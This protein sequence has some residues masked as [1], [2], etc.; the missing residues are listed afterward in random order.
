[1]ETSNAPQVPASVP[2]MTVERFS[3]L[4]GLTADTIRGQI[5]QGNLPFIKVGRRRL[6]NVALLTAEC[7]NAEDWS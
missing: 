5:Q 1:M 2:V 4:S 3:E 7:M 6:V